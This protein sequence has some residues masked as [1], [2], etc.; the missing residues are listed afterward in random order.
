MPTGVLV[1]RQREIEVLTEIIDRTPPRG[2]VLLLLGDP[3]IGKSALLSTAES[4]ARAHGYRVLSVVGVECET[5][6]PFA[7]LHQLLR[8]LLPSV[9]RLP[10]GQRDA[11]LSAFGLA[12][13]PRPEPFLIA[14]AAVNLLAAAA[15]DQPIA[16]L[17]DDVQWLD[18]QT[19]E[20]LTFAGHRVD[21]SPVLIIGAMRTGHSGPFLNAGFP[22]LTVEG[23]DDDA[24]TAILS[25]HAPNLSAGERLR[26]RREALGNPLALLELPSASRGSHVQAA[27]LRPSSLS[28][29]LERAF[30][31]RI[32]ELPPPTR[33]ALLITT[34]DSTS[35][36]TEILAATSVLRGSD[37]SREV[38]GPAEAAGLI[39]LT[40]GRVEFRHPLMRSGVL[41]A[42]TLVRLQAANAALADILGDEPYRRTWHRAQSI[43]GPDD[44]IADDLEANA[45]VALSRGA[46]MS[47]IGDLERSAQLTS[48]SARRGHRLLVAAEHA[49]GLG[50]VDIVEQLLQ[51]AARTNLSDLDRARMEW[52]REI[53]N[54]GIPGDGRRVI[55][56]SDIAV[57]SAEAG[58]LDLALNLLLGAALRCWWADTGPEAR[59]RVVTV[60]ER[61][62]ETAHDPRHVATLGVAE[63]VLRG[64]AVMTAL[65]G[66]AV[67]EVDNADTLRLLGMA[68]HAVGHE[69]LAADLLGRSE[70][71]L[72][73]QGRL[74]LLSHVLSMQVM[75]RV[76]LGHLE[77]AAA[78]AE[79]G[80]RLAVETG[81]PIWRT[82]T[83]VCDSVLN[84]YLGNAEEALRL[85]TEAELEAGRRKLNDLLSCVQLARGAAWLAAGR[86]RDAYQALRRAFDPADP[87]FHQR[88]RFTGVMFLADAG[89]RAGHREDAREVLADLEDVALVTPS[90]ILHVNLLYAR[91]VLADDQEAENLYLLAL[92][93][94][95]SRWPFARAKIKLAY[96][97]WLRRHRR[98]AQARSFLR[99]AQ[100]ALDGIG[101]A[102]WADEARIELHAA[103][104]E[105][106]WPAGEAGGPVRE[107]QIAVFV[108][109]G[110]PDDEIARQ[111]YLSPD[112]VRLYRRKIREESD[113]T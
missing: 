73:E 107:R 83:L 96:G 62:P 60:T 99:A 26:I 103:G 27:G 49:F 112:I 45:S 35:D 55:E 10:A 8:P 42:E 38:F 52:L 92:Q 58:D 71:A 30:A 40:E 75:V 33:D 87:S 88:E 57:R 108:A 36:L 2:A 113:I 13:G 17:A 64:E 97:G 111:L 90:P 14:L 29:R 78:A 19:H 70:V 31:G 79:E 110:L 53:F 1:G 63:P 34:V 93:Q 43:I 37:A 66:I 69:V 101:A 54:D 76:V 81:Q 100:T 11:L 77:R 6:L 102:T 68:A 61:M 80:E 23:V 86:D 20:A 18:P 89:Q 5:T 51:A 74:G 9:T 91:A 104:A 46:V 25:A 59:A 85:A 72:R 94:D 44:H 12:E 21:E 106:S 22:Q 84:A 7:G 105:I 16:I 3:G 56:L 24:A 95:L 48:G 28:N 47:A 4:R 50:R 98:L 109:Q 32:A 15:A 65:A 39:Y 41:Q 82:G 67:D